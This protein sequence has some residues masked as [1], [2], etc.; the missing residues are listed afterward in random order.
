MPMPAELGE[1]A[2]KFPGLY[3]RLR[4]HEVTDAGRLDPR[5][6]LDAP[7]SAAL[8]AP[9]SPATVAKLAAF[10]AGQPVLIPAAAIDVKL[11]PAAEA[12]LRPA[13]VPDTAE[14][15]DA[16][17]WSVFVYPDDTVEVAE[18]RA[19]MRDRTALIGRG[20]TR[21]RTEDTAG[22]PVAPVP[23]VWDVQLG[24]WRDLERDANGDWEPIERRPF[25]S[26]GN[27]DWRTVALTERS[28]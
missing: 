1:P 26:K 2:P 6:T 13:G 20:I 21:F 14:E 16:Q 11:Y 9:P 22:G 27:G 28:R 5:I 8:S 25:S 19:D 24:D 15:Y 3:R 7:S 23:T 18:T 4:D 17:P 12:F 10:D